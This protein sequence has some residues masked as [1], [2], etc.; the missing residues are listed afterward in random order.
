MKRNDSPCMNQCLNA[1]ILANEY[2]QTIKIFKGQFSRMSVKE[3][4]DIQFQRY[5]SRRSVET[6]EENSLVQVLPE[7][8]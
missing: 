5:F 7:Q 2:C 6:K 8:T 3:F 1:S 4:L